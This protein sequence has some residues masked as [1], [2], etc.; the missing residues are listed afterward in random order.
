VNGQNNL[1]ASDLQ[2]IE[3]ANEVQG[4]FLARFRRELESGQLGVSDNQIV[5]RARQYAQS[6]GSLFEDGYT[7]AVTGVR[8]PY[9]PKVLTCCGIYCHCGWNIVYLEGQGNIDCFWKLG[10]A[11]HCRTCV[12]RSTVLAPL[13]IR[14]GIMQP[15]NPV[16]LTDTPYEC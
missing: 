12:R 4:R 10:I 11:E 16:G 15:F 9:Q 7:F 2:A 3:R 8:L 1:I 13:Q 14:N 6:N 5:A